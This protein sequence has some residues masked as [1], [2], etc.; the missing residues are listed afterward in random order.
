MDKQTELLQ[1]ITEI[2]DLPQNAEAKHHF[3]ELT[4]QYLYK[5]SDTRI[6]WRSGEGISFV[7]KM[8]KGGELKGMEAIIKGIAN[9]TEPLYFMYGLNPKIFHFNPKFKLDEGDFLSLSFKF[10][11]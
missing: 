11:K 1:V 6:G 4:N 9:I 10:E 5:A 7:V 8:E 3:E 2:I